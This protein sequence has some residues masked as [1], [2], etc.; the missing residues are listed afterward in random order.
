M[1]ELGC[2][3]LG[4]AELVPCRTRAVQSIA[5]QYSTEPV[6]ELGSTKLGCAEIVPCRTTVR[7][8]RAR[9]VKREACTEIGLYSVQ[10][11]ACTEL[12]CAKHSCKCTVLGLSR[13]Y[14][15]LDCEEIVPCRTRT[16]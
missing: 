13:K 4:C 5:V 2:T 6:Q 7:Q 3:K 8:Y 9:P 10:R 1:Q 14:T 15:K 11:L 16:V 12:G